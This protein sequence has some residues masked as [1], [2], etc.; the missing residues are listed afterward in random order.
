MVL[1][2]AQ[3]ST[4]FS[5]YEPEIITEALLAQIRRLPMPSFTVV[6]EHVRTG[7]Q[8]WLDSFKSVNYAHISDSV[9]THFPLWLIS[10]WSD[11]HNLRMTVR[12]PWVQTKAWLGTELHQKVSVKR[13]RFA[14]EVNIPFAA[15]PWG[16][17]KSGV[18]NSEP[19][20]TLWRYLGP[21]FT[22][23]SQQNDLLKIIRGLMI[24]R[25]RSGSGAMPSRREGGFD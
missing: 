13:C 8:A 1:Q 19:I 11:A 12:D 3:T 22:T 16:A 10:F 6:K 5:L 21:N 18:S 25:N 17:K 15:L 9:S 2:T 7:C 23:G 20:H 24:Y 14:E 4:F